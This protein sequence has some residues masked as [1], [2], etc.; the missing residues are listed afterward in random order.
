[1]TTE[2]KQKQDF[3][4]DAA[5]GFCRRNG[6]IFGALCGFLFGVLLGCRNRKNNTGF[7]NTFG[8][9]A[10]QY[11]AALGAR[12][13]HRTDEQVAQ[14]ELNRKEERAEALAKE[15]AEEEEEE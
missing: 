9:E 3:F 2:K 1:M 4:A 10:A 12:F 8:G 11:G 15:A 5:E 7:L 13:R 14:E 6:G